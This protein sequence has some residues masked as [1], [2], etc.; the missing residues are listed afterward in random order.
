MKKFGF[1][2]KILIASLIVGSTIATTPSDLF[3]DTICCYP[4]TRKSSALVGLLTVPVSGTNEYPE[5]PHVVPPE[6]L[7]VLAFDETFAN[8]GLNALLKA[9]YRPDDSNSTQI[10]AGSCAPTTGSKNPIR[11]R[12]IVAAT[13]DSRDTQDPPSVLPTDA[14]KVSTSTVTAGVSALIAQ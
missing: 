14:P 1:G 11:H 2:K 7:R 5:C 4:L 12:D 13:V 10:L 8:A 6:V 3:A 9:L